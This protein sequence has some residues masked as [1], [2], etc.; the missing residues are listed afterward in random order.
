MRTRTYYLSFFIKEEKLAGEVKLGYTSLNARI[1]DEIEKD[2]WNM[3]NIKNY[4][5]EWVFVRSPTTQ[6]IGASKPL[7]RSLDDNNIPYRIDYEF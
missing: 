4:K 7:L 2:I 3:A 1:R 6:K 5:P